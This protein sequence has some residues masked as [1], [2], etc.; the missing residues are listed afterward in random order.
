MTATKNKFNEGIDLAADQAKSSAGAM[1]DKAKEGTEK[2]TEFASQMADKTRDL[3]RSAVSK[4]SDAAESAVHR[5][6]EAAGSVGTSLHSLA[7]KVRESAPSGSAMK[8]VADQAAC[9]LEATGDY[10]RQEGV[11]GLSKDL[12]NLV[13]THPIPAVFIGLACGYLLAKATRA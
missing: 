12:T 7:S 13:R 1:A 8:S 5:A 11:T 6:D 9:S 3:A 10:L 4:A 2:A